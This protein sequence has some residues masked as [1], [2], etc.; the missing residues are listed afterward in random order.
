LK[1][2]FLVDLY[3]LALFLHIVG[4]FGLFVAF[5]L[6]WLVVTRLGRARTREEAVTWMGVMSL[7][8]RVG[9]VSLGLI[10][11]PGLYMA[12]TRW[13]FDGWPG[14]AL[15]GMVALGLVGGLLTGRATAGLGSTIGAE[16]GPLSPP[17]LGRLR[18]PVLARSLWTRSA[19][20]LGIV[21]LMVFKPDF[22]ASLILLAASAL[23]GLA[24][25]LT[26]ARRPAI[27][28]PAAGRLR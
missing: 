7:V 12:V 23:V 1:W 4:A 25:A 21:G 17:F 10:L 26:T 20:A 19:L 24:V 8:R 13:G 5:G 2:S 22:R 15:L 27:V 3:N 16:I 28:A 14:A 11:L 18:S 6:E 9:P